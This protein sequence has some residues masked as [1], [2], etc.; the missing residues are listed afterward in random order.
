MCSVG[1]QNI[2]KLFDYRFTFIMGTSIALAFRGMLAKGAKRKQLAWK[3]IKRT[4]ILFFLGLMIS[5]FGSK[6]KS[7]FYG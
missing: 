6:G 3:V 7:A 1:K 2:I 4:A 5:N